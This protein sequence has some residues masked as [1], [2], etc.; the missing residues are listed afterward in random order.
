MPHTSNL[1]QKNFIL[2]SLLVFGILFISIPVCVSQIKEDSPSVDKGDLPGAKFSSSMT[3]NGSSL[4]GYID[5]GAEL[6]LEYGF[7]AAYVTEINFMGGKYKTEIYKMNGPEEA[8]GIFSVSKF[9]C[10]DMPL[11]SEFTCRTK[12]QLQ[13]CKGPY[14]ISI[15]NRTGTRSDSIA[16]IRIGNIIAEKIKDKDVD[17]SSYLPGIPIE[18]IK[19]KCILAR[20]KLGIINGSP[21]LEDY[22]GGMTGYTAVIVS[23]GT[24]KIISVKFENAESFLRFLELHN[25]KE[26]NLENSDF[27]EKIEEFHLLI[28]LPY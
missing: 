10:Q 7:S 18:E 17:L 5:G 25:W 22:F 13:F 15:I 8:F 19:A 21:D 11:L 26:D 27:P 23:N 9:H 12:Y 4:F 1:K 3:Y 28:D 2:R 16:S 14:Y 6:Y 24:K 20:G